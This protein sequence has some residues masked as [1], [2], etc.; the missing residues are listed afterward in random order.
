VGTLGGRRSHAGPA[1]T[2]ARA[3]DCRTCAHYEAQG[4]G[5]GYGW[6]RAHEQF[7]KLYQPEGAFW[8][9]CQF[10][11]LAASGRFRPPAC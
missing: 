6:C 5:I 7:V 3:A 9:H 2:G 11:A 4:D 10:K 8:S 1:R